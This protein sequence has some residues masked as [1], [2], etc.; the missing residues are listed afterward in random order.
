MDGWM[1]GWMD[2]RM[3]IIVVLRTAYSNQESCF[4][5]NRLN[6]FKIHKKYM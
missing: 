3:E 2:G 1:D 6:H 5:I 4:D